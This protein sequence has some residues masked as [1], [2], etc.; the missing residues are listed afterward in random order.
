MKSIY[1][2]QGDLLIKR[3]D[4]LP[5]RLKEKKDLVIL[6]GEVTAHKHRL[7][8]GKVLLDKNG[9]IFLNVPESTLIVHEEHKPI[10]L[11]KGFYAII[12]QREYVMADM[13]RTVVD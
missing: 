7:Q 3:I 10:K 8:K 12:R 1:S 9:S 11:Q 4:S 6:L 13:V 5:S 2:R